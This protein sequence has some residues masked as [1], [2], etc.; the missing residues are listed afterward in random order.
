[1]PLFLLLLAL[2]PKIYEPAYDIYLVAF[3]TLALYTLQKR[4]AAALSLHLRPLTWFSLFII[5]LDGSLVGFTQSPT[6]KD[7]LRDLL[8]FYAIYMGYAV[9]PA[10]F[11]WPNRDWKVACLQVLS[12][13]GTFLVAS[14]GISAALAFYYHASAYIWRGYYVLFASNWLPFFMVANLSL[15]RIIPKKARRFRQNAILC[16]VGSALALSR[17]DLVLYAFYFVANSWSLLRWVLLSRRGFKTI[18][19][20]I[21]VLIFLLPEFSSLHVVQQRIAEGISPKDPSLRW[22]FI[23]DSAWANAMIKGG[24]PHIIVGFGFGSRIPLPPGILDFDGATSVPYLHN[25]FL[26]IIYKVGIVGFTASMLI[27]I[28]V[29]H[30]FFS[31]RHAIRDPATFAGVWIILFICAKAITLQGFSE[32]SFLMFLGLGGALLSNN[33][34]RPGRQDPVFPGHV[35]TLEQGPTTHEKRLE[36]DTDFLT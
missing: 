3:V 26:T 5:I 6:A 25:S 22:R 35:E 19:F 23:E 4:G 9:I 20:L 24:P 36:P 15:S 2:S 16:V 27:L 31:R 29:L 33:V 11:G 12:T 28:K 34:R 8:D 1:M 13:A 17:T 14:V 30:F 21:I 7:F 10:N 32:W 18:A